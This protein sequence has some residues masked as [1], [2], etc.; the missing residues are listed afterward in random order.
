M[1]AE[2]IERG[3]KAHVPQMDHQVDGAAAA[4]SL[5]P[6]D[7]FGAGDRQDSRGGAPFVA[8]FAVWLRAA[9]PQH[10]FKGDR[11]QAVRLDLPPGV[12][13]SWLS[14]GRMLWHSFMFTTWLLSVSRS[15]KAEVR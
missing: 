8:I 12:H 11:P 9:Q 4:G 14:L 5:A 3:G 2:P 13:G 1:A 15:S 7:K 6:V 10:R